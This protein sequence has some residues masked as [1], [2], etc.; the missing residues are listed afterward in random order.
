VATATAAKALTPTASLAFTGSDSGRLAGI[1]TLALL[2]GAAL[3]RVSSR[4]PTE[5]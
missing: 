3:V 5:A 1:A 2:V 4:R